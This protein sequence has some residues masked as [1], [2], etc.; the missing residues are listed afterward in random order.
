MRANK[1]TAGNRWGVGFFSDSKAQW[2][3]ICARVQTFAQPMRTFIQRN[4]TIISWLSGLGIPLAIV[5]AGWIVT[6]GTEGSKIE[7]EYV[8]M[9]LGILSAEK[10]DSSGKVLE[11]TDDEKALRQWAV[12]LLNRQAPEKFTEDEQKALLTVRHPLG[13]MTPHELQKA[14]EDAMGGFLL[15]LLL[16]GMKDQK[17]APATSYPSTPPP[18]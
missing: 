1:S 17:D 13:T 6:S 11:L 5:L 12:R 14:G 2:R 16:E 8:K 7:S 18:K 3:P 10:K 4:E 15:R 9:A